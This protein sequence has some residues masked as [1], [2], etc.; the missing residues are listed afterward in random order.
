[1]KE[2]KKTTSRCLKLTINKNKTKYHKRG[3]SEYQ[4]DPKTIALN[5]HGVDTSHLLS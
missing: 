1:M 2:I 5:Y 3:L 4:Y